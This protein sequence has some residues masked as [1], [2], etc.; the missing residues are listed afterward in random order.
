MLSPLR[1]SHGSAAESL[2]SNASFRFTANCIFTA[3]TVLAQIEKLRSDGRKGVAIL[4]DPDRVALGDL[5]EHVRKIESH[6]PDFLFVGGSLIT[7]G[8]FDEVLA[9]V[10]QATSL[11]VVLFP[12]SVTQLSPHVDAVLFL[13]LISGRNPE[14]LIGQHVV[15]APRIKALQL[16][17]VPTG[18]LL[19][20]GGKPTTAS[21][22]SNTQP[23]PANKAGI[24]AA[25]ALAGELLGL[26]CI[27]LDAGSGAVHPVPMEMIRA[28]REACTVPLIVGGGI[29]NRAQADAAYAAGA[30]LLVIGTAIEEEPS[31]IAE[32]LSPPR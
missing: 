32:F 13:S 23:I 8:S 14:L 15:A 3:V 6:R 20:D 17:A 2:K 31:L 27:Y 5:T 19:I 25:T 18:Y 10:R 11:P 28:V 26:R 29:R 1:V 4:L 16:E 21:Y 30:D 7:T 12:G 9:T 22:I 24:A